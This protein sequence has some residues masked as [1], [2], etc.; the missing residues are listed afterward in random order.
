MNSRTNPII[1]IALKAGAAML[2]LGHAPLASAQS[3]FGRWLTDDRSAIVR[4]DHC[5]KKLCG[6]IERVLNPKAPENDVNNPNPRLRSKPLVGTAVLSNY[7]GSGAKWK[8]GLA[9]DPKAGTSYRSELELLENGALKVTGCVLFVCRSRY[10]TR[11][12]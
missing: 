1:V 7:I 5:G 10:W 3:I 2:L 6:R 12:D 9:Y 8:G 4:I 11:S